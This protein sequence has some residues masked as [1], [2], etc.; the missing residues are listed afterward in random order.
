MSEPR[1][2]DIRVLIVD[3]ELPHA[4][5]TADALRV[6]GYGVDVA[7]SGRAG[8]EMLRARPYDLVITDLVLGDEDGI[9]LV[10]ES[11]SIHPF[12]EVIVLTGHGTVESAVEAMR[13]GATDYLAKPVDIQSLRVRVKKALQGQALKRRTDELERTIDTRFGFEGIIG[14]S[15]KMHAIIQKLSQISPTDVS[16][17]ILGETGTGKELI[18]KAIH[19]NSRRKEKP[20]VPLNCASLS[21]GIL[22][23]ELFGH[24]KGAFTGAAYTRKGRFEYASGGTLFLDEV[25]DIPLAT[26]IKLLRVLEDRQVYRIGDNDPIQVDVRLLSATNRDLSQAIAAGTFREDLFFR[27]NVVTVELPALR[28]RTVDI[29]LLLDHFIHEYARVHGKHVEGLDREAL[30]ILNRYA[31]PGNVRE[32][33]N[34]VENMV[35]TSREPVL[36][37]A[38]LP[39]RLQATAEVSAETGFPPVGTTLREVEREMLR[40][41]LEAVK[42]NRKEAAKLLGIGERTL[43]RKI[44]EYELRS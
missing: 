28:E 44:T 1:P 33:K 36:G 19:A 30:R 39:V 27:L 8:R 5:A 21:E 26:Q 18:A 37:V 24:V 11:R 35:V 12:T 22:E 6:V 7:G 20:F 13:R 3:D 15:P 16:V 34:V 29:P 17:L 10:R 14:S 25:G 2:E 41:T 23:S 4:E 32:L 31:W 9:D 38:D 43:Y 40:R 42:G